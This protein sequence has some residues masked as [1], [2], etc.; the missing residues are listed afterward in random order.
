[1]KQLNKIIVISDLF[2]T[3]KVSPR[4]IFHFD[5]LDLGSHVYGGSP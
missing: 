2:N 3:L 1:M 5:E 4:T